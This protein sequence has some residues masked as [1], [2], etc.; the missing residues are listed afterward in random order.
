MITKTEDQD[1]CCSYLVYNHGMDAPV[2]NESV[3]CQWI[4]RRREKA[5]TVAIQITHKLPTD[6]F[7]LSV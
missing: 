6:V 4:L 1:H 7:P 2:W 5:R 3:F